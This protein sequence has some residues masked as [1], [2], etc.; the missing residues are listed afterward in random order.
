MGLHSIYPIVMTIEDFRKTVARLV[1]HGAEFTNKPTVQLEGTVRK[2]MLMTLS[3]GCGNAIEFKGS[4]NITDVYA[5]EER[6]AANA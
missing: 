4:R 2:Q 1:K 5:V 6:A 3:D